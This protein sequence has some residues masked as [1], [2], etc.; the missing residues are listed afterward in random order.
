MYGRARGATRELNLSKATSG[1]EPRSLI[2]CWTGLTLRLL[3]LMCSLSSLISC[4]TG[5]TKVSCE[6]SEDPE[7]NVHSDILRLPGLCGVNQCFGQSPPPPPSPP[8]P[9]PPVAPAP[10]PSAAAAPDAMASI[11]VM[12]EAEEEAV[13][14]ALAEGA[15]RRH[16]W[17]ERL[18]KNS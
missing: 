4:W 17:R 15:C 18:A 5:L 12:V 3:L 7:N 14:R 13:A 10:A 9:P 16:A 11:E 2:T 1:A 8:L 6:S